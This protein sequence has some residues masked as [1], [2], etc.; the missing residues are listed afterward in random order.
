MHKHLYIKKSTRK[1]GVKDGTFVSNVKYECSCGDW[2]RRQIKP[3]QTASKIWDWVI[4][5]DQPLKMEN[6]DTSGT[7]LPLTAHQV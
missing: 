6:F 7:G 5:S 1:I 3:G 4:L 2:W